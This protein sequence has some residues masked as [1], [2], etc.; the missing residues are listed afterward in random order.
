MPT[1]DFRC[2]NCGF[3]EEYC[4]NASVPKDMRPP[5]ICPK[6]KQGKMEKLFSVDGQ[7]FDIVGSCYLNDYGK[8]AWKKR[9]SAEEQSKVLSGEKNPY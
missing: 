3:Q 5:E 4:T 8:H 1:F 7:S 2:T 6:C 9:M